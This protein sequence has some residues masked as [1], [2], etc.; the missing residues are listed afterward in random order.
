VSSNRRAIA[1]A[2]EDTVDL[3]ARRTVPLNETERLLYERLLERNERI[4]REH[5]EPLRQSE[6][7]LIEVILRRSGLPK[8]ALNRTHRLDMQSWAIVPIGPEPPLTMPVGSDE[9]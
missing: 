8:D 7:E 9:A 1:Q 5:I 3:N 4:R 6:Q 2:V